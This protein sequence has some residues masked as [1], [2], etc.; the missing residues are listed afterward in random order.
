MIH[1]G[2]RWGR[3]Y[4]Y[5]RFYVPFVAT[6][7]IKF[8]HWRHCLEAMRERQY[9]VRE[10]EPKAGN[11]V[12]DV[13]AQ[14]ADYSLIWEKV[15]GATVIAYEPLSINYEEAK[16]NIRLNSSHIRLYNLAVGKGTS[17]TAAVNNSGTML[18]KDGKGERYETVTL[19]DH[20]ILPPDLI[21]IDVEGFEMD[22]LQGGKRLL[23]E[24]MPRTIVETHSSDLREKVCAFMLKLGFGLPM[25]GR[26]VYGAGWMNEI[27]NLYFL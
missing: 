26:T 7:G 20:V 24:H 13:G 21:K 14:F 8:T 23:A 9:E 27:T 6:T 22:V 25:V 1:I 5:L 15:Y 19:D 10:F 11:V 2:D 16:A 3:R 4:E 12:I 18:I 17:M